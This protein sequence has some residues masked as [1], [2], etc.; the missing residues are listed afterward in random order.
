MNPIIKFALGFANIPEAAINDLEKSWPGIRHVA[1]AAKEL[2]PHLKEASPHLAALEPILEK[3]F[4]I[5]KDAWPDMLELL[6][7]ADEWIN[8]VSKK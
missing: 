4:P 5:I 1:N 2:E 8:I 7:V 6:P 3:V